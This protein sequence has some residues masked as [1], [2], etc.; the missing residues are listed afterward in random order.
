MTYFISFLIGSLTTLI[1]WFV[2]DNGRN[3][4]Y[5]R[6]FRDGYELGYGVGKLD[7]EIKGGDSSCTH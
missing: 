6:G 7:A 1:V 3:S 4:P 5:S 2:T